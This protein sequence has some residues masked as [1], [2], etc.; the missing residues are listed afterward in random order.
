MTLDLDRITHPLRLAEGS[1]QPGSGKGC[2]MNV[3]SYIN[4]DAK[5]TDYPDC[6]ARPLA[7]LVQ[8]LNDHLADGDGFLSPENSLIVLDLGWQTV[9][10]ADVPVSVIHGWMAEMLDN[11]GWGVIRFAQGDNISVVTDVADLHR[12]AACGEMPSTA[13]WSAAKSE[14][15][16]RSATAWATK[17]SAAS[18]AT[19]ASVV[20]WSATAAV[21]WSAASL[22]DYTQHAI[23]CWRELA[24]LDKA[25]NVD[26]KAVDLALER[27]G[28]R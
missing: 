20:A 13:E 23:T 8:R 27:I 1:H 11:P 4:G 28:I 2:A 21:S 5:I 16:S 26:A 6:S 24:E 18:A 14:A 10:T 17:K 19:D 9:G 3:I 25:T 22:I 7:V 12:K 15:A